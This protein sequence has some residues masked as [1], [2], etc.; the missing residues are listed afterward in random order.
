MVVNFIVILLRLAFRYIV[1]ILIFVSLNFLIRL[2][3]GLRNFVCGFCLAIV[4]ILFDRWDSGSV[5][6]HVIA[7]WQAL[8]RASSIGRM[9]AGT[10]M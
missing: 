8:S 10:S 5:S 3:I 7:L 4:A 2:L 9:F 1:L 6:M